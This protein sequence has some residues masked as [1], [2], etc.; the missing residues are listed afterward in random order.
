MTGTI[1]LTGISAHAHHG[2]FAF[3]RDQGQRFVIDVGFEV[4]TR[5][6]ARSDDVADT[7]SYAEVA[8]AV[9][10]ILTGEPVN[11]VETLAERIAAVTLSFPG[12]SAATVVIHK[13]EA[14]IAVPFE[15]VTL[16]I[17]RTP[18]T[19]VPLEPATVVLGLGGN[20]GD[21][22]GN[23]RGAVEKLSA[24]LEDAAVGPLVRTAAMTVPGS[25]PQADYLNT[26]LVGRTRLAPLEVLRFAQALER[27]AGRVRDVR[28]GPRTLDVDVLA[29]GRV[30]SDDP[31][32]TLPHPGAAGR[33]F[34]VVPWAALEPERI[35]DGETLAARASRLAGEIK[36]S[37]EAWA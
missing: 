17:H 31:E 18:L 16:T 8:D 26:V 6:A 30:T 29:H 27:G 19:A 23:L 14:P 1:W 4:D 28:W 10:G 32:L 37:Q 36:E 20:V 11:L 3:E 15:D 9:H 33:P 35:L 24:T 25:A 21:V 34:V 2:V 13:P 7:V 5:P 22:V 12:V